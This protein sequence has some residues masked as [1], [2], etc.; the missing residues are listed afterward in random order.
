M[1]VR[2]A[3]RIQRADGSWIWVEI[4]TASFTVGDER[5][6]LLTLRDISA[7]KAA[8]A[9]LQQAHEEL[10]QR[11]VE[12]TAALSAT[13]QALRVEVRERERAE[14]ALQAMHDELEQRIAERTRQLATLYE[15][16]SIASES[17]D[18]QVTMQAALARLLI[19]LRCPAGHIALRNGDDAGFRTGTQLGLTSDVLAR[20]EALGMNLTLSQW[21]HEHGSEPL[22][23]TEASSSPKLYEMMQSCGFG[24]Y[25][26]APMRARGEVLGVLSVFGTADQQFSLEDLALLASVADHV[27]VAVENTLLRRE[28]ERAAAM[29]ER[30]R[31]AQDLHDSVTQSVFSLV[32]FAN[33]A[34]D[35]LRKG[36]W[37]LVQQPLD[38]IDEISRQALKDLRLLLYE[39]RPPVLEE[40]GLAGALQRRLDAVEDRAGMHVSLHADP[41]LE[42]PAWLEDGL[43]HIA[44]EALNN[45]LKHARATSVSAAIEQRNGELVMEIL[46]D[47]QGFDVARVRRR[48]G[49]GLKGMQE[50]AQKLGGTLHIESKPGHGTKLTVRVKPR[51]EVEKSVL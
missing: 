12:R 15:V 27:G 25:V 20:L 17:L 18:L 30:E 10:E 43:Y 1:E 14:A 8:E 31:L 40:V 32:L 35:R 44:Q 38:E 26:G 28:A 45:V 48:G 37:D 42:L 5:L 34:R 24:V 2:P 21:P 41:F 39:L 22:V 19:A 4:S 51:P 50:R 16:T 3:A 36:Q 47:G 13:N 49:M 6:T 9:A 29:E 7:R 11:V 33:T 46:D 23:I